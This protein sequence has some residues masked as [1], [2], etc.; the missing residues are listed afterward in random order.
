MRWK[1]SRLAAL[2][3]ALL[4]WAALALQ[5]WLSLH[6]TAAAGGTLLGGVWRYLGYFTVIANLFAAITLS[7]AA[8][9]RFAPRREF[10]A[11]TAMILVGIVY[12]LLLRE[13]WNPQG[14]QKPVDVALHDAMPLLM[15]LFW[16][17]R[18]RRRLAVRDVWVTV[19][20][21]L[22]YAAYAMARGALDGWYPYAF[23]DVTVLGAAQAARNCL[24][25]G[26]AFLAMALLLAWLDRVLP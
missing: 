1:I 3:G 6:A 4:G 5:L 20:L 24:G 12:S 21:P 9:G 19:I 7:L 25:M 8:L 10:A 17:L 15:V 16:L 11:V 23:L 13:T 2:A 22:G 18:P 14:L 26:A